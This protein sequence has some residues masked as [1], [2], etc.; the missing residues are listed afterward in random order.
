MREIKFRAKNINT[1]VW[2]YG[3]YVKGATRH[4]ILRDLGGIQIDIDPKTLGQF[5]GIKGKN[6][7]EL[8]EGDIVTASSDGYTGT[9][10]IKYRPE[11]SPPCWI[12][13]PAWQNRQFWNIYASR[14]E[15]GKKF[16]EPDG[17]VCTCD[18]DDY[19]D[20]G[21]VV[22]GNIHDDPGLLKT[23]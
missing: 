16:I 1:G 6:K 20:N 18:F 13:Y 5:I 23:A 2:E 22:I 19:I 12:L 21:I 4:C 9:F 11:G 14:Y 17:K 3:Y 15:K 10:H 7:T 8:Y